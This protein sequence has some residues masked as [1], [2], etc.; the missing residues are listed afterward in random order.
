ME[1]LGKNITLNEMEWYDIIKAGLKFENLYRFPTF[2][3]IIMLCEMF[4]ITN[5]QF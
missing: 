1:Y 2:L 4:G 3:I 5:K